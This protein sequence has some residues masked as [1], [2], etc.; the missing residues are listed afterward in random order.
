MEQDIQVDLIQ[1]T[2]KL[3]Q[4]EEK[5][6]QLLQKVRELE[7]AIKELII[8]I[9]DSNFCTT[10]SEEFGTLACSECPWHQAKVRAIRL[11]AKE[12]E[13]EWI[14]KFYLGEKQKTEDGYMEI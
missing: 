7:E 6:D 8:A 2:I 12:E 14:E 13:A 11:L 3:L 5:R 9:N 4:E 1:N 10:C